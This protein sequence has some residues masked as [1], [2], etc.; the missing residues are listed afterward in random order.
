MKEKLIN[1]FLRISKIPRKS[2]NEK[3]IY[4]I[5]KTVITIY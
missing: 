3:Q 2:G 5:F 1:N 4:I